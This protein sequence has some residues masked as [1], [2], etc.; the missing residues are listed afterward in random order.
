[1]RSA[2]LSFA[3]W[4]ATAAASFHG[5]LN[6]RSPS[7]RH[8]G[9]GIDVPKVEAR[10]IEKRDKVYEPEELIFTHGVASVQKPCRSLL[11]CASAD[12]MPTGR[13]GP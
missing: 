9:L 12:S 11:W 7:E 13:P 10:M 3:L 4:A 5:N 2:H 8:A 1:M 6:Y